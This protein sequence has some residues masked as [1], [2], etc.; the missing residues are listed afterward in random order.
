MNIDKINAYIED[1]TGRVEAATEDLTNAIA[2]FNRAVTRWNEQA[3]KRSVDR[4][5]GVYEAMGDLTFQQDRVRAAEAE[6]KSAKASLSAAKRMVALAGVDLE[7][8]K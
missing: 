4:V 5:H 8:G 6:L 1:Y 3:E 7:G 2:S